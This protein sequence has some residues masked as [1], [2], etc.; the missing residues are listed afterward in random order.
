MET[1][2]EEISAEEFDKLANMKPDKPFGFVGTID[3]LTLVLEADI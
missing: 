1:D 3:D 2:I